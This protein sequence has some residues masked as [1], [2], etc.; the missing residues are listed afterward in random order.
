M[1]MTLNEFNFLT[2]TCWNGKNPPLTIDMTKDKHTG[3]YRL[4][5]NSIFVPDSSLFRKNLKK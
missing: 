3:Q 2:S 5:S 1:D 4:G